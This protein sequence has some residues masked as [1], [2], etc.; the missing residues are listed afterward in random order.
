MALITPELADAIADTM[1][2]VQVS[3]ESPDEN[4]H[5]RIR[6]HGSFK[7]ACRGLGFLLKP[8]YRTS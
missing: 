6:G 5:D 2:R 3:L 4:E 7:A 8:E 1:I